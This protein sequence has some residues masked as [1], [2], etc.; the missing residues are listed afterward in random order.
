MLFIGISGCSSVFLQSATPKLPPA[1]ERIKLA[2]RYQRDGKLADALIQWKILNILSPENKEYI[3][4]IKLTKSRIKNR[5]EI[6][7]QA[8]KKAF[9]E[10]NFHAAKLKFLKALA[11]DP[12]QSSLAFSYLRQLDEKN[13]WEVQSAK[14][15]KLK[16]K[17]EEAIK[18]KVRTTE[19]KQSNMVLQAAASE[20]ER[21]YFEMGKELLQQ[22][23]FV[24]AIA[25]IEKYLN[26]YPDDE[27]A[28]TYIA[29]AYKGAGIEFQKQGN[30]IKA[31]AFYEKSQSYQLNKNLDQDI[32]TLKGELA[33]QYYKKAIRTYRID[34]GEAIEYLKTGLAYNPQY[35]D[36]KLLLNRLTKMQNNLKEIQ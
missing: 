17:M 18:G 27:Q 9:K 12:D 28:K 5:V 32:K 36:A 33:D 35:Y 8:G 20:E 2:K 3:K 26:S 15:D 16:T 23:N 30:L 4:Q 22:N 1:K 10:G 25:E 31:L 34:L 7:V 21:Y 24:G 13:V 6:N 11:L 19:L 14:L 29:G